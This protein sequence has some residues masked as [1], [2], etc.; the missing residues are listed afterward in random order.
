MPELP[1]VETTRRGLEPVLLGRRIVGM[2]VREPRL[3]WPVTPELPAQLTG[4]RITALGRRAKYLLLATTGGTL[5]VHLGMSGS[6]R[7]LS[8][9]L[10][11][12]RHDHVDLLLD[13]GGRLRYT[14]PRRFGSMHFTT[15][16][17]SHPLLRDLGPEPLS[18]ELTPEYLWGASRGRRTAIKQHLMNGRIVV[19]LGNIYANEALFLAGIHPLRAANRIARGR[20]GGLVE[21]I[22][23]VLGQAL[24][25]G[26][27]T[28]R[29]YVN[30]HG[31]AGMFRLS[32]NVYERTGEPC[33][34]CRTAILRRVTGQRS[35]Y[36]CPR[37]Q[38]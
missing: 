21:A 13:A 23:T 22:R 12:R 8:S 34:K 15:T 6:L 16:P 38:R 33:S 4:T 24:E 18:G 27:T 30:G 20:F 11:P 31:E 36:Y 2:E 32:L 28:L 25:Q 29:D 17:E 35:T 9:P 10:P 19:G 7:Y 5:L 1:E 37:C 3:R 26:G 14:D